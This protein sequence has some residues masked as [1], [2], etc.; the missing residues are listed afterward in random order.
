MVGH[1]VVELPTRRVGTTRVHGRRAAIM[2][3]P[4]YPKGG[5]HGDHAIVMWNEGGHGYLVS[6]HSESSRRATQAAI[7]IAR[8]SRAEN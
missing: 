7:G 4:P 5:I 8:S 6:A 2:K 1:S 3:A